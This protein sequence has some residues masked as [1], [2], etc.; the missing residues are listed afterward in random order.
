VQYCHTRRIIHRDLKPENLLIDKDDNL[1]LADFGL[2]RAFSV[3]L[4]TYTHE[5]V[6]L[7]YRPP[8]ILLSSKC[9]S[10]RVD[11]WFVGCIFDEMRTLKVLFPGDS[12]I[13]R[14]ALS[15]FL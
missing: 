14:L 13:I 8:E 15:P 11:V 10:T 9:Y 7:Y 3:P 4:Q 6:S 1:T 5:V 12:E 2:G